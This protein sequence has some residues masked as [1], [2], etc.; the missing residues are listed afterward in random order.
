M[1]TT[2]QSGALS[3]L[4]EEETMF[5]DAVRDFAESEVRPHVSAMDEAGQFR[6]DVLAK[7]W[8]MGLMGIEVP[9]KM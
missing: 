9:E 4:S 3:I 6:A 8:E 2:T 7:F 5:R 1:T